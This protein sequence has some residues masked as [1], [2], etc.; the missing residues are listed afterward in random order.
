MKHN[1]IWLETLLMGIA[2]FLILTFTGK[3][4]FGSGFLVNGV[5]IEKKSWVSDVGMIALG[6]A[7]S[8][9]THFLGHAL[10]AEATQTHWKYENFREYYERKDHFHAAMMGRSGFL[11][12]NSVGTLLT[13]LPFKSR[14]YKKFV[15]GY[16]GHNF[17]A[18]VTYD[19][20][21]QGGGDFHE[22]DL[23]GNGRVEQFIYSGWSGLNLY[24]SFKK[25]REAF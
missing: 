8:S 24:R 16:C 13:F 7:T 19:A 3:C 20:L 23:H 17:L 2:I 11:L 5:Q 9:I 6:A 12:Q 10:Y 4:C 1:Q 14:R 25:E 21:F 22:I 18:I 15:Q